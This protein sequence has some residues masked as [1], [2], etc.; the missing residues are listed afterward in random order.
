M[1]IWICQNAKLKLASNVALKTVCTTPKMI[2][3]Q[4]AISRL[5]TA[6]QAHVAKHVATLLKQDSNLQQ[7]PTQKRVGYLF[8]NLILSSLKPQR[9]YHSY[10]R[11]P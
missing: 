6:P 10:H 4:Q 9:T 3:A 5:V 2:L 11:Y 7:Y 1:I 8:F